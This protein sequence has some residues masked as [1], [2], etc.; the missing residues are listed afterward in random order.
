MNNNSRNKTMSLTEK[1]K[2][3]LRSYGENL[4]SDDYEVYEIVDE[5]DKDINTDSEIEY[6]LEDFEYEKEKAYKK[7]LRRIEKEEKQKKKVIAKAEKEQKKKQRELERQKEIEK[8]KL[9][10]KEK[11]RIKNEIKDEI[12]DDVVDQIKRELYDENDIIEE[13]E[14]DN[15]DIYVEVKDNKPKKKNNNNKKIKLISNIIFVIIILIIAMI[16]IDIVRVK[17]YNK[18][19]IFAIP[20]HTYKD[21]GTKEYYG[22]GYKV[23]DYYQLQGRRDKEMGTWFL[24]YNTTPS[25]T[26]TGIDLAI[27]VNAD[28]DKA[29]N[30]YYNKYIKVES[31]LKYSDEKSNQ[32]IVGYEDED[33]KYTLDIICSMATDKEEIKY[34]ELD[35]ETTI[36]G[37]VNAVEYKTGTNPSTLFLSNCFAEQ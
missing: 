9:L 36:V 17:K 20:L 10:Q 8:R 27:E 1:E 18:L 12:K 16:T 24:K 35:H 37:T 22:I 19:P 29:F 28:E 26:I 13:Y 23:I 34:L 32:I 21:G 11:Y 25:T 14:V 33:D 3:L 6:E 4:D 15:N 7:E 2:E 31:T 5:D 30:K